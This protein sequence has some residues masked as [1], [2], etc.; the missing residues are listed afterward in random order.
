MA[1]LL[2]KEN[3]RCF[4]N[5]QKTFADLYM[6]SGQYITGIVKRLYNSNG[7]C[8]AFPD[9]EARIQHIFRHRVYGLAPTECIYRI[10]INYIL[11]F[12]DTI[13]S[14]E[15]EYLLRMADSL[16]AAKNGTMEQFLE[17]IF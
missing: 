8:K 15:S 2:G 14:P 7:L 16:P 4:D 3:P 5:P 6:E 17:H 10:A 13:H 9:K 11:D 1:D 12:N